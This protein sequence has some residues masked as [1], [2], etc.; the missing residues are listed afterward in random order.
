[1]VLLTVICGFIPYIHHGFWRQ[2]PLPVVEK[3]MAVAVTTVTPQPSRPLE[4][5][6]RQLGGMRTPL[7]PEGIIG[8][9]GHFPNHKLRILSLYQYK[10]RILSLYQS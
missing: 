2:G 10:L 5:R 3:P 8:D 6:D 9:F 1:M 7:D 4:P